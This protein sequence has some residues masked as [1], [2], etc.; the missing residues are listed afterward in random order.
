MDA[1]ISKCYQEISVYYLQGNKKTKLSF[2]SSSYWLSL[3]GTKAKLTIATE[4]T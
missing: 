2:P 3:G 1:L 4:E